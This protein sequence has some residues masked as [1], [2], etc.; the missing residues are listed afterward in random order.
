MLCKSVRIQV[1]WR[2]YC[3]DW[4]AEPSQYDAFEKK[5]LPTLGYTLFKLV[6]MT[7]FNEMLTYAPKSS[8]SLI[9]FQGL[10]IV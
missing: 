6:L 10:R 8:T 1:S 7:L 2:V 4:H 9:L 3:S 5:V